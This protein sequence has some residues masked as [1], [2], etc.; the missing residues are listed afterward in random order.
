MY[1]DVSSVKQDLCIIIRKVISSSHVSLLDNPECVTVL[2]LWR[3]YL[4]TNGEYSS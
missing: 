2:V 1:E 4:K 3:E